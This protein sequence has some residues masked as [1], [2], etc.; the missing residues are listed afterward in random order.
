MSL[1]FTAGHV[2]Y[3]QTF[4]I[5]MDPPMHDPPI[6]KVHYIQQKQQICTKFHAGR[7]TFGRMTVEKL[8][9]T[10]NRGPPLCRGHGHRK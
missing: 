1:L 7:S 4:M 3:K 6:W 8:F 2:L 10:R 9:L 5:I